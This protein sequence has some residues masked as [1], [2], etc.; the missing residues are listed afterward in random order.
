MANAESVMQFRLKKEEKERIRQ[1][2]ELMG[3]NA[4]QFVLQAALIEAQ[5][6]LADRTRFVLEDDRYR[7]FMDALDEAPRPNEAL[8]KLLHRPAPWD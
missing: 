6:V 1:G 3:V 8:N 7:A 5:R 4:S 2:A